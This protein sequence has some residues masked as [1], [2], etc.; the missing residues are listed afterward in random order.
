MPQHPLAGSSRPKLYR[1][2]ASSVRETGE[3]LN[4]REA[5]A[6]RW[7]SRRLGRLGHERR[8][9]AIASQ[10]FDLTRHF[11]GLGTP[12]RRLLRL[13]CL[14]HDVGRCID[15]RRH[16]VEGAKLLASDSYLPLTPVE[17]RGLCYLTR[18]HRGAVPQIGYDEHLLNGDGRKTLRMILA[19][20]RAADTLDSRNHDAPHIELQVR[21]RKL[22]ILCHF[23]GGLGK[24]KRLF[25]RRKKFRLLE[26][27]LDCRVL[28]DVRRTAQLGSP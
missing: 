16:P 2:L 27:L 15:E 23:D 21:G 3:Q 6:A 26:E 7:A 19:L 25:K 9:M 28:V 17:R 1:S 18:Y 24:A 13:A 8:V 12:E 20:L 5:L 11:H 4:S 14:L 22:G 10:L